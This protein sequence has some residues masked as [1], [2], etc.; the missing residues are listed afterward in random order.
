MASLFPY[1]LALFLGIAVGT[2]GQILLK[3]GSTR[4]TN[5]AA[6]LFDLFTLL[7][8]CA[9][10]G[11]A[12]FYII[13]IKK[14]PIS[15]AYPTVSLSYIVVAIVAHYAWGEALGVPQLAGIALIAGGILL[16]HQ[17]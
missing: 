12:I 6:Q 1:Y 3:L 8:L 9:Y 16:L 14:L 2:G 5:V 15:I 11:A 4:T 7:G 13:A 17:G 10:A